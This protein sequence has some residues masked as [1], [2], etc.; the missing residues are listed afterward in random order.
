ML[1]AQQNTKE[2][3]IEAGIHLFAQ[4]GYAG[5]STRMISNAAGINMNAIQFHFGGKEGLYKSVLEHVANTAKGFYYDINEDIALAAQ[6][7]KIN[8]ETVRTFISK[9]IDIQLFYALEGE[10]TEILALM[11]WEQLEPQGE[12]YMPISKVALE[13]CEE[14][15]SAL[16][17]AANPNISPANAAIISRFINGG[18]ISFGEHPAFVKNIQTKSFATNYKLHIRNILKPFIMDCIERLLANSKQE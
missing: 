4:Y 6:E 10:I 1:D 9:L 12:E 13:K 16:F 8:E 15:L 11:Y 17:F 2:K 5:T 14:T 3:L 18:I 7:G